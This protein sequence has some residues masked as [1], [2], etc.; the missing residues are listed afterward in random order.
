MAKEIERR[1]QK[2][3]ARHAPVGRHIYVWGNCAEEHEAKIAELKA[4][5]QVGEADTLVCIGWR[6][7]ASPAPRTK[8]MMPEKSSSAWPAPANKA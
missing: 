3:E 5:G 4:R 1:L 2:V 7:A 6:S 8:L